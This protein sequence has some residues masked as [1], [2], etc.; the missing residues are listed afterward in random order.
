VKSDLTACA[1]NPLETSGLTLFSERGLD[2][3]TLAHLE[4]DRWPEFE[5]EL[6]LR[7]NRKAHFILSMRYG[8]RSCWAWLLWQCR[9]WEEVEK[10]FTNHRVGYTWKH[11][12]QV[13]ELEGVSGEIYR[14]REGR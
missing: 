12:W 6:R 14:L 5:R 1:Q 7:R 11:R 8:E 10:V 3:Q 13:M 9:K 2:P 4:R